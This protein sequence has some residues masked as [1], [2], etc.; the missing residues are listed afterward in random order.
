MKGPACI[1][2][3]LCLLSGPATF[4]QGWEMVG[5]DS[6][7]WR[8][9][10]RMSARFEPSST[11][12]L[13]AMTWNGISTYSSGSAWD[14]TFKNFPESIVFPGSSH[15]DME[16]IPWEPDSVFIGFAI[17]YTE[18]SPAYTKVVWPP[19]GPIHPFM[20]GR[21]GHWCWI[22]PMSVVIPRAS[23]STVYASVCG[24]HQSRDRGKTWRWLDS[25]GFFSLAHV[26]A[27]DH[28]NEH[29]V[30]KVDNLSNE[31]TLYRS[32]DGGVSWDSLYSPVPSVGYTVTSSRPYSMLAFG[33][34]LLLSLRPWWTDTMSTLGIMRSTDGGTTWNHVYD[35]G[36]IAVLQ[37][38]TDSPLTIKAAGE[39]GVFIS[40]DYGATWEVL[41]N[42]LPTSR[43]TWMVASPF[44]D[45]VFVS[46]ETHGVLKVWR[47]SVGV[48]ED[49]NAPQRIAL[50]QNY[51]NP[52]NPSTHIAFRIPARTPQAGGQVSGFT[53]LRVHDVLGREVATLVNEV[54]P[55]GTYTVTWDA[56]AVGSGVYFYTL[57]AG[58]QQQTRKLLLLR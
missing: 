36:R 28:T 22:T 26:I 41:N 39:R 37:V 52:F 24:F 49:R 51:P 44:S 3:T 27:T 8:N 58:G 13:A 2:V 16:F 31:A 15:L 32:S 14:Y 17:H 57:R 48:E 25:T 1:A 34:T 19:P 53:S 30:Y 11:Y 56:S 4:S 10:I 23:D 55:P 43:I 42:G 18:P 47:F 38:S 7:N 40:T 45:T 21:I 33:D 20:V 5:P 29:V 6:V 54:K 46:T 35:D 50:Y 12:H 9:V